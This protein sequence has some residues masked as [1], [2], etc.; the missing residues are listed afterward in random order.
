MGEIVELF[1]LSFL[2]KVPESSPIF[3]TK[4]CIFS[5]SARFQTSS[6]CRNVFEYTKVESTL[7]N[8]DD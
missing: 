8:D 1:F 6:H 4:E 3:V 7:A 2:L 5:V